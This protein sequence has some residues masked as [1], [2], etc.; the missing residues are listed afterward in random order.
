[1]RNFTGFTIIEIL[2]VVFIFGLIATLSLGPIQ[3][4][5][6]RARD[7]QRKTDINVIVQ[8]VDLYIAEKKNLPGVIG[9]SCNSYTSDQ[10]IQWENFKILI[11]SYLP[12]SARFPIDPINKQTYRYSY[13]CNAA[14]R[15]FTLRA[16]LENPNDLS[17]VLIDPQN[18]S[19]GRKYEITH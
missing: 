13:S 15:T 1:M 18:V 5:R 7:T 9:N 4:G 3:S 11:G 19:L 12:E 16:K 2:V 14:E 17:G 10:P 8:G 6:M